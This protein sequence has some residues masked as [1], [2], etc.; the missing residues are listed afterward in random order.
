LEAFRLAILDISTY[1]PSP[2]QKGGRPAGR[3]ARV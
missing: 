3:G 2:G 1:T